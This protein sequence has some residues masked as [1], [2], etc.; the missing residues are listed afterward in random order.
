MAS[1][2]RQTYQSEAKNLF[3]ICEKL[4]WWMQ[5]PLILKHYIDERNMF[6][7]ASIP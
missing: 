5:L 3:S 2:E 6:L 7:A 1:R 4:G